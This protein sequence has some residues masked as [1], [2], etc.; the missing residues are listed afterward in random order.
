MTSIYITEAGAKLQH[1]GGRVVIGRNQE[2]LMEVPLEKVEDVS[3]VDSVQISSSLLTELLAR[4]VPITWLSGQGKY[5]GTLINTDTV[6]IFKQ[7]K[8]FELLT[9]DNFYFELSKKIIRAKVNNQLVVLRRYSRNCEDGLID[10]Q[11]KNIYS[12]RRRINTAVNRDELRGYEGFVSRVYFEALGKLVPEGFHFNKRS[13][14]P[15]LDP[16]NAMLSL[17]YSMLFNEV[18]ASIVSSGLHPF[19]GF[20]HSLAKGHPALASDL[21]EEWRAP[22]VDTLVLSMVRKHMLDVSYF[23][24]NNGCYLT[25]EGRKIFLE[26]YNKKLRSENQYWDSKLSYRESI[27]K[28]VK[29]YVT[30][31]VHEDV[32]LYSPLN[33][34]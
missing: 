7:L 12:L 4:G 3:L 22:I 10:L 19:V 31:M 23:Q 32:E 9:S 6:D 30:A 26:A 25:V 18:M 27:G 28:Q 2:V 21:M 20:M 11:I 14:R 8:Q 16:F 34:E 5:F 17:G 15:P 33:L 29:K 24:N 13:R 1:K